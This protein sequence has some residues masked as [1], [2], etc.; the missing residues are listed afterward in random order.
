[1]PGKSREGKG[2]L[3]DDFDD[4]IAQAELNAP[5]VTSSSTSGNSISRRNANN[6]SANSRSSSSSSSSGSSRSNHLLP[7]DEEAER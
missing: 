1:M 6:A 5:I 2:P 7:T 3:A 4:I